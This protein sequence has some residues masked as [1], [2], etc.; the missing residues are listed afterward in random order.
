MTNTETMD[1]GNKKQF[2]GKN[3]NQSKKLIFVVRA[4][5]QSRPAGVM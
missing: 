4:T 5:R 1:L 2:K 3:N